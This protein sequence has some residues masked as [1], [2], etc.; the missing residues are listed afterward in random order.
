ME[1][2]PL[3]ALDQHAATTTVAAVFL[4]GQRTPTLHT[5]ATDS[6]TTLRFVRRLQRQGPVQCCYEA[7]PCGF[8]LQR[9]LV[10]QG[11]RC[12]VIAPAFDSAAGRRPGQDGSA[13]CGATGGVVSRRGADGDPHPTEQEAAARDLLRC[14]EDIRADLLRARHRLRNSCSGT[15]GASPRR[16]PGRSGTW[17]QRRDACLKRPNNN[18]SPR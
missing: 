16:R 14:R 3:V 10:G 7:G 8:E 17:G 6:L 2:T 11:I 5:L 4:P 1:S 9:A 15:D 13:R 18:L 12:D